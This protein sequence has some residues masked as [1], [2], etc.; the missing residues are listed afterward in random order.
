MSIRSLEVPLNEGTSYQNQ[1]VSVLGQN[2]LPKFTAQLC[3]ELCDHEQIP[4]FS[5]PQFLHLMMV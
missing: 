5:V 2:L 1:R 4:N 3:L